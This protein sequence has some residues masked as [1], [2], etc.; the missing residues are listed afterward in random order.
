MN[1]DQRKKRREGQQERQLGSVGRWQCLI[2]IDANVSKE[3]GSVYMY[4]TWLYGWC[5]V[6]GLELDIDHLFKGCYLISYV[7]TADCGR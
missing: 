5:W 1:G 4:H 7:L 2:R 3:Y 6:S